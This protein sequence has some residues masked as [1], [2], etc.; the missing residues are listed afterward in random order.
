MWLHFWVTASR[1]ILCFHSF[2]LHYAIL[3]ENDRAQTATRSRMRRHMGQTWSQFATWTQAQP[4]H[5]KL[6]RVTTSRL[7]PECE[8]NTCSWRWGCLLHTTIIAIAASY[9]LQWSIRPLMLCI[10]FFLPSLFPFYLLFSVSF[11]PL[12]L[13]QTLYYS[14]NIPSMFLLKGLC[15]DWSL[16]LNNFSSRYLYDSH[17]YFLQVNCQLLNQAYLVSLFKLHVHI[18]G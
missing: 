18:D 15:T 10:Q 12:P 17:P 6:N 9:T 11:T 1:D 8:I 4:I 16:C 2:L 3:S 13:L 5:A 7:T 14:S